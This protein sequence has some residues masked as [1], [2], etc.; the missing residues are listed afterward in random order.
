MLAN[1]GGRRPENPRQNSSSATLEERA[2]DSTESPR[3]SPCGGAVCEWCKEHYINFH[4][5]EKRFFNK[6]LAKLPPGYTVS[7]RAAEL[8][9]N[10]MKTG[11]GVQSKAA[12]RYSTPDYH[13]STLHTYVPKSHKLE[14]RWEGPDLVTKVEWHKKFIWVRPF[15]GRLPKK[16]HANDVKLYVPRTEADGRT[17]DWRSFADINREVRAN[18]KQWADKRKKVLKDNKIEEQDMDNVPDEVSHQW[19][20]EKP[21]VEYPGSYGDEAD[22]AFWK[23]RVV[24]L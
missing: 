6:D 9:K 5:D 18:V 19:W 3:K 20:E 23:S 16:Y 2:A 1:G 22:W 17:Q 4:H 10:L 13:P 14:P 24:N 15:H 7:R 21:Q 12:K 11:T 8:H